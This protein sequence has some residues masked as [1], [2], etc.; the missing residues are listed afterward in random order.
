MGCTR[1]FEGVPGLRTRTDEPLAPHTT[2]GV[3]GTADLF[4]VP[5]TDEALGT[6][7]KR[8]RE[9]RLPVF[10][11]G[12]G[13]NVL[14]ADGG[15]RGAVIQI[16]QQFETVS[17]EGERVRVGAGMRLPALGAWAAREGL[18]GLEPLTGI[19][20]TVGGALG[21]NAG[22]FGAA[23][24]TFVECVDGFSF[25]GEPT[26]CRAGEIRF[27][28]REAVYP[29]PMVFSSAVLRLRRDDPQA[30]RA[31]A[32][33]TR[34]RRV[35]TQPLHTRSAGCV[36]KN[37]PGDS[38]GRLID[39][40]GLKGYRVGG[41]AVSTV[42]ANY[43]INDGSATADEIRSLIDTVR[44]RVEKETGIVLEPEVRMLGFAP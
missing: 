15:F 25:A 33:E 4:L 11:L 3:G 44:G 28:Y 42:H 38:A 20:G 27:G 21:I 18:A 6:V 22:A 10:V 19:P 9:E 23:F 34:R 29:E 24:G 5:E 17:A 37:P 2:F 31:R 32:E 13:T 14:V 12:G 8:C 43:V 39:R 36:F 30:I 7:L 1:A 16:T 41:A 26:R 40:L 35:A